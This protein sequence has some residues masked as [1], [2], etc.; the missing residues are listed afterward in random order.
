MD[1]MMRIEIVTGFPKL[2]ESPLNESI[3]RQA[4]KKGL[5]DIIIHDLR[6]YTHDRHNTID[7]T[8]YGG[9][10]GMILKPEPLFECVDAI[11]AART[12]NEVILMSPEG[13]LLTQSLA[14][15]LSLN[16]SMVILCGHYKGVDDRVRQGLVTREVSIG[17]FVVSGGELPALVLV[18]ALV[19]LIPG[20]LGNGESA[21]RDSFQNGQLDHPHYT[22][23]PEYRGMK[24]PEV[25]LSGNHR[26]IEAWRE[27][28][29]KER[30]VER[31]KDLL[32]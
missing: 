16:E 19:R 3:I 15:E 28:R 21:L 6:D 24:V 26:E 7:D 22:R 20:V 1:Q 9:G 32:Q 25:L 12:V 30:T 4:R 23:P 10:P 18:D 2:V 5:I 13:T 27:E 29:T 14:N 11:R 31:R 17:D 8:P